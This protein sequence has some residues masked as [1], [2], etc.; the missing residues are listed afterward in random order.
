MTDDLI[1]INLNN[2]KKLLS[3][4]LNEPIIDNINSF[5]LISINSEINLKNLIS[6]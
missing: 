1:N 5:N 3:E 6:K 2:F 4:N